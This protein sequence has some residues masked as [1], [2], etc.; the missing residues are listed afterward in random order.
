MDFDEASAKATE[1]GRPVE[2]F[3]IEFTWH[4]GPW[5]AIF[6]EQIALV[7]SDIARARAEDKLVVYLSCPISSRGGGYSAANVDIAKFVE[8]RLLKEWGDGFWILNPAQYQMES[9]AGT[10][11]LVGHAR[12][13]DIDLVRLQG[14]TGPSGGDYMRMWTKVLV[15]DAESVVKF[16][17]PFTNSGQNFDAYYFIGPT[18]V[19]G[20]FCDTGEPLTSGIQEYFARK[21]ATDADF[22]EHFSTPAGIEWGRGDQSG[23]DILRAKWELMRF[24]FLRFYALR[25]GVNFSLGSHDELAILRLLNEKRRSL[26]TGPDRKDGDVGEQIAGFF[27]GSQIDPASTETRLSRG[28]A[29]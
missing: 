26:T 24:R 14:F 17:L 28:Y 6:D 13:L 10:G 2:D 11:L 12:K 16:G 8:R 29:Q 7:R 21:F 22:R 3:P 1:A 23:Q 5:K 4:T 18:D 9:K 20:F 15:E 27:D 25:A 19:Q